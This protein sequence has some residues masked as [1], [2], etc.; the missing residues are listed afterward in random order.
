MSTCLSSK[1]KYTRDNCF[2]F[3][4]LYQVQQLENNM[5]LFSCTFF[6]L[7]SQVRP[8]G[9]L[10]LNLDGTICKKKLVLKEQWRSGGMKFYFTRTQGTFCQIG[11]FINCVPHHH[12]SCPWRPEAGDSSR[13]DHVAGSEELKPL[14]SGE[15]PL[16]RL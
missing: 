1:G 2:P 16:G 12:C 13:E 10:L 7:V 3:N 9:S 5:I 8:P 11:C 4:F 6:E 15:A 14:W